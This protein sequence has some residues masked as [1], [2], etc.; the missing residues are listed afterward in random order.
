MDNRTSWVLFHPAYIDSSI[1]SIGL[2]QIE[3][4]SFIVPADINHAKTSLFIR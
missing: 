2:R 4:S 1:R 3:S